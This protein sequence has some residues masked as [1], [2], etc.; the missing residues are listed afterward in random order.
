VL[1]SGNLPFKTEVSSVF[2]FGQIESDREV[3]AAAVSVVLLAIAFV[4]LLGISALSRWGTRH[5]G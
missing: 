5:D 4:V 2:I 3:T 1:I